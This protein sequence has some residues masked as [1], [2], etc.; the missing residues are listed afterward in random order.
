[1]NRGTARSLLRRRIN[2]VTADNWTDGD[3]NDILNIGI[4]QVQTAIHK[5]DPEAFV[6]IDRAS[7]V[8]NQ[9]FYPKPE[10]LWYE[11]AVRLL[12]SSTG[13]YERIEKRDYSY[14]EDLATSESTVYS[15]VGRLLALRPIPSASL[16]S[17][18][19]LLYVPTLSVAVDTDIIPVHLALHNAVVQA[20]QLLLLPETGEAYKD[21]QEAYD[22]T[23]LLIPE[24]Y[25]KSA[26]EPE[27]FSP[28]RIAK[29]Y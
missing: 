29:D 5:V 7:I 25:R 19:E 21:V 18:L 14:A 26:G 20:S 12:N 13:K 8:A 4:H 22:R 17:G 1:M 16:A 6:Y 24:Y 9:E 27:Q 2:E 11:M 3:L 15:H 10:G 28:Q 23:I